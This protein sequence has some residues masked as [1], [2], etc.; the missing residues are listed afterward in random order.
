MVQSLGNSHNIKYCKISLLLARFA[1]LVYCMYTTC[2]I[3]IVSIYIIYFRFCHCL[4][5]HVD[6]F[7]SPLSF[8][9]QMDS[10]SPTAATIHDG[11]VSEDGV[12][13]VDSV[14]SAGIQRPFTDSEGYFSRYSIHYHSTLEVSSKV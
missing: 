12:S 11:S 6:C 7:F 13:L 14:S 5:F 1:R 4:V 8:P 2:S 10:D 3:W 9:Y